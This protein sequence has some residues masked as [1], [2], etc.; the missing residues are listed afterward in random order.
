MIERIII[1][2][3]VV[4]ALFVVILA[5]DRKS[6]L[7]HQPGAG[8]GDPTIDFVL[9]FIWGLGWPITIFLWL[10]RRAKNPKSD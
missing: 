8:L 3:C 4:A 1:G 2:Y 5:A 7:T 9:A 10:V 6:W